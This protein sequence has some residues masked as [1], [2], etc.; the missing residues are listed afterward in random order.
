MPFRKDEVPELYEKML[1]I[2]RFEEHCG[3]LYMEGKIRGF[4]HLYIGEEAIAVG[5]ISALREDD[6]VISHYRDHG[7]ALSRGME[8]HIVMA[9]LM[10]KVTG[11]SGGKGGSMHLFD[12]AKRFM[13]GYAIVGGQLPIATGLGL[14]LKYRKQ[15]GVV[16]CFFGDGA[17]NEGEFH[18]A[19]NLASLWTLPVLF[20]LENNLY[21][22]GTSVEK[23]H[24]AGKDI[25]LKADAYKIPKAQIDGM[26]L[27]EVRMNTEQALRKIRAGE[28]PFFIEALT[29]RYKGHSVADP[30]NYRNEKEVKEWESKDPIVAFR[31][32]SLADGLIDQNEVDLISDRVESIVAEAVQFAETSEYPPPEALYENVYL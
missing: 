3:R 19:L 12:V 17:V 26:D 10:G 16:L 8:P 25:Y 7:H 6:F 14:S 20:F 5:S 27:H 23:S 29:Y 31:E 22:M 30:S 13:G 11:S 32:Q 2:R 21:G 18:E 1:L 9:E 4:L 15:D 24:A 28:G